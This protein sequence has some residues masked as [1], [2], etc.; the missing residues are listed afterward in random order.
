LFA[1]STHEPVTYLVFPA[2]IWAALRFGPAGASLAIA[3]AAGVAIGVTAN[4]VGP[5]SHQPIDHQTLSTQLYIAVAAL[6]ALL[7]SA[8]VSEG[9]RSSRQLVDAKRHE[10]ERA[11][12]ERHRIARDLHDSVSQALFSTVLHTRSAQRAL[13][14][15]GDPPNTVERDLDAI[16]DLARGAQSE[17]RALIAELGRDPLAN[18]LVTAIE[19]Y[20]AAV[21]A[22]D[23]LSIDVHGVE[24]QL[25]IT[26]ASETQLFGI[27]REALAN[28]LKHGGAG[29]AWVTVTSSG[30]RVAVEIQDDGRGFNPAAEHPGHFGLDSMRSRAAEIGAQLT[31]VSEPAQGTVVRVEL[32]AEEEPATD[33]AGRR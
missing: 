31:I 15:G 33:G 28:V 9:E 27:A 13:G 23:G 22:R 11:T 2:L 3:I 5:F 6:T 24:G 1:M 14:N 26:Q 10:D 21:A 18:G 7:L 29:R 30:E 20:A 12:K 32:A 19:E 16:G 17:M 8:V 25:P 4:N